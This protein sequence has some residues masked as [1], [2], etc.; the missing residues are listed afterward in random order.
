MGK[1]DDILDGATIAIAAVATVDAYHESHYHDITPAAVA[2]PGLTHALPSLL[3]VPMLASQLI[4][5]ALRLNSEP[6]QPVLI[7]VSTYIPK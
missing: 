1:F 7:H 5:F 2:L 3:E 4:R 6:R